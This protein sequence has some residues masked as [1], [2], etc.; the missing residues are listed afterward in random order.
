MSAKAVSK[1]KSS[2]KKEVAAQSAVRGAS[3]TK[4]RIWEAAKIL[5]SKHNYDA[6]GVREIA[7][8]AGVDAALVIR[9]FGSKEQLFTAIAAAAFD[10]SDIIQN[11]IESL[12]DH[13]LNLLFTPISDD[14]WRQGYDPF[15]LL[16]SSVSSTTAGPI[17]AQYFDRDFTAPIAAALKGKQAQNRARLLA[18]YIL[19]FA[20]VRVALSFPNIQNDEHQSVKL[21]LKDALQACLHDNARTS[22]RKH[23]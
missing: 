22:H 10:S 12:P 2:P 14:S 9:Y 5:F 11:G 15:R 6:V 8:D 19:G 17:V 16:L 3:A 4:K 23:N 7:S 1:T 18:S 21:L 13:A 20:L